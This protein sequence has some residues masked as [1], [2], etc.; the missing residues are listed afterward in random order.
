MNL[1][2]NQ[3]TVFD[4]TICQLG[5]GPLWHP[6]NN[7]LFW[8]DIVS[9]SMHMRE[10]D[11]DITKVW[12]FSEFVTAAH[13]IDQQHLLIESERE[14]FQFNFVS[15]T[16]HTVV[17]L[18]S[19]NFNTRSN[20]GRGDPHGGFW[21]S[22]MSLE[23][24]D[25]AGAIYR[26]FCG[27]L[28]QLHTRITIPNGICFSPDGSTAYFSDS[29]SKIVYKQQLDANGWPDA[30]ACTFIDF[31]EDK[32]IPDGACTDYQGNIWIADWGGSRVLSHSKEGRFTGEVLFNISQPTCPTFGGQE[33]NQLLVTSARA[34]LPDACAETETNAGATF[35][36][37]G[38]AQGWDC[39]GLSID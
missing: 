4:N 37:T 35:S 2:N 27:E 26:Y 12:H 3:I 9:K 13:W 8:F 28:R 6:M 24:S 31:S 34:G 15:N 20:D 19:A 29:A 18:E 10:L 32:T 36:I 39:C 11:T 38:L 7:A 22:T 21:I 25:H 1:K 23:A 16:R 30:Q 14:L 17:E 5:E 33:L